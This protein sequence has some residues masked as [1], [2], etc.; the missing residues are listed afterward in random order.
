MTLWR[1]FNNFCQRIAKDISIL[2]EGA[3]TQIG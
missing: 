3:D 2:A 1:I